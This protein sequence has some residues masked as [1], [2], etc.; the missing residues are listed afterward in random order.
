MEEEGQVSGNDKSKDGLPAVAVKAGP[1]DIA[2]KSPP[3][4]T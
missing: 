2:K 1:G 3:L 4:L